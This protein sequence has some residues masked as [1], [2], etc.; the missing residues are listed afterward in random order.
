MHCARFVAPEG[1]AKIDRA[2]LRIHTEEQRED[3]A[4]HNT[5]TGPTTRFPSLPENLATLLRRPTVSSYD[6]SEEN[7]EAFAG[8]K[9]DLRILYP[10]VHAAMR[11]E[12]PGDRALLFM[13]P[14]SDEKLLPAMLCAHFD[15][16]P[17]PDAESWRHDP[18]SGEIADGELWGRGA[19]DIKV[20]L[21][22]ILEAA[23]ML[24]TEG[25]AP[26]RTVYFAFGGDEETGG[27]RGARRIAELLAARGERIS[28]L[29]DEGGPIAVGM[30]P[31]ADIQPALIG[32]AEKGYVDFLVETRGSGGHASMPPA[33]TASGSLSAAVAAIEAHPARLRLCKTAR[34]FL[35]ALAPHSKQ[36]YR[37]LFRSIP[38]N[39]PL[40]KFA[41]SRGPSTNAMVRTTAAPTMLSGSP[42]ENVLADYAWA[43]INV[44]LLPGDSSAGELKRLSA[45][46]APFGA[47]VSIRH[48]EHVVEASDES[49]TDHEGWKAI[50]DALAKSHAESTPV[51]FLFSAGT[52]TKHYRSLVGATYRFTPLPQTAEDL[53]RVHAR[54]ERVRLSD[55]DRCALFFRTLMESL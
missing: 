25:F 7:E 29:V 50:V 47:K 3:A 53:A 10:R 46:A 49:G 40:I 8:L 52:D 28:F 4:M 34:S 5:G 27:S 15:V 1:A 24:I 26:K 42:K 22:S 38:I 54:D 43:N 55:L 44:R 13:W 35:A 6:A 48:P 11:R 19:Q 39:A 16:V 51:P 21:A 31:F 17:A 37:F 20:C 45:L 14:G 9:N 23:E 33:H 41:F 32:V 18:F 30:L 12:E 36:P 2:S